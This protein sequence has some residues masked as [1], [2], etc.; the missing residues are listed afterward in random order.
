MANIVQNT[1]TVIRITL[2]D[3]T[4]TAIDIS[5]LSADEVYLY[6]I[7]NN[8]KVKVAYFKS[9]N[10]GIY[11]VIV[12]DA[13]NGKIDVILN[14][15]VSINTPPGTVYAETRI[16]Q[17]ATSTFISSVENLGVNG[18]EVGEIVSTANATSLL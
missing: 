15:E 12:N 2:K 3:S 6:Q 1:D 8:V 9:S 18:I 10:T 13:P 5:T 16:R 11:D 17:T 14:R 4:G 7:V